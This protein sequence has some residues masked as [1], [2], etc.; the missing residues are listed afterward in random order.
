[1]RPT[2]S[3]SEWGSWDQLPDRVAPSDRS[4]QQQELVG[5]IELLRSKHAEYFQCPD[6]AFREWLLRRSCQAV[7]TLQHQL[8]RMGSCRMCGGPADRDGQ[9]CASCRNQSDPG[10][11]AATQLAAV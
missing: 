9:L 10:N 3:R 11:Q 5:R 4:E 7:S 8:L 2:P 1:M 6:P